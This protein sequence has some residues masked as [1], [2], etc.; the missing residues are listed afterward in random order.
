MGAK[1]WHSVL[2]RLKDC[3]LTCWLRGEARWLGVETQ[4]QAE[5]PQV[6]LRRVPHALKAGDA[7]TGGTAGFSLRGGGT[8]RRQPSSS[9]K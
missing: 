8:G 7:Q 2:Q 9:D 4:G 1:Q 6:L 5:P 3:R